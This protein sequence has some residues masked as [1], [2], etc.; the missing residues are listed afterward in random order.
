MKHIDS[1]FVVVAVAVTWLGYRGHHDAALFVSIGII[2]L[3]LWRLY[4]ALRAREARRKSSGENLP[5]RYDANYSLCG[6]EH[7]GSDGKHAHRP[8]GT[9]GN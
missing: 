3:G 7:S 2:M 5:C 9:T 6:A 1:I 4:D 8:E